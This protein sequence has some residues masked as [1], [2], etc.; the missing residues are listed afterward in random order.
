MHTKTV[1]V[2]ALLGLSQAVKLDVKQGNSEG[3]GQGIRSEDMTTEER[4]NAAFGQFIANQRRNYRSTEELEKRR[5]IFEEHLNEIERNNADPDRQFEMEINDFADEDE[6]ERAQHRGLRE[7][8]IPDEAE[9]PE[10]AKPT[11]LA[12]VGQYPKSYDLRDQG[13]C[14]PIRNQG[15]CG[16]CWAF[17]NIANIE[18]A[19]AKKYGYTGSDIPDLSEQ[20]LTNCVNSGCYGGHMYYALSWERSYNLDLEMHQPYSGI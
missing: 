11:I 15:R 9:D 12:D 8:M 1:V 7:D 18:T 5:A 3:K 16:S 20:Q 14:P 10:D 19:I 17:A 6:E 13:Q 4:H 2:M